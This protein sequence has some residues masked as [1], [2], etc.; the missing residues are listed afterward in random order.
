MGVQAVKIIRVQTASP[1][2]N[3]SHSYALRRVLFGN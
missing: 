3:K 2:G 1:M